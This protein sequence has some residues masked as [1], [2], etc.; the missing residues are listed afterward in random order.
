[1]ETAKITLTDIEKEKLLACIGMAV[2]DFEIKRYNTEKEI[3]KIE[4]NGGTDENVVELL[5]RYV[6]GQRFYEAIERK[7]KL[8]IKNNQI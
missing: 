4:N 6:T 1:M 5:E 8:A 2:K 3:S 7:I